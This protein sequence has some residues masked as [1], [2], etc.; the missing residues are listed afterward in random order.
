METEENQ[1]TSEFGDLFAYKLNI[2]FQTKVT[3]IYFGEYITENSRPIK[4]MIFENV[5]WQEF[6]EFDFDNIFNTIEIDIRF[7][8]FLERHTEYFEKMKNYISQRHLEGIKANDNKFY[9]FRQSAGFNCFIVTK[10]ELK[11]KLID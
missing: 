11:I 9:S 5:V 10:S 8:T 4:K 7:E 6:S 1:I 3:E 2:N